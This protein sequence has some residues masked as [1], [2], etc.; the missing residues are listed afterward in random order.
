M[1]QSQ[2]Y[3]ANNKNKYPGGMIH[4][5]DRELKDGWEFWI[6]ENE[7]IDLGNFKIWNQKIIY[8][9]LQFAIQIIKLKKR[10]PEN[11]W[12]GRMAKNRNFHFGYW[13]AYRLG[14]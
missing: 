1:N 4:P 3:D 14:R 6:H 13:M 12:S 7:A 8:D 10:N 5:G 2:R 9:K 11:I